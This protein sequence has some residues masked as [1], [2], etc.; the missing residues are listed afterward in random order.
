M[1]G[2]V[3]KWMQ[4]CVILVL[5]V[6]MM[7]NT[8]YASSGP[9]LKKYGNFDLKKNKTVT[10]QTMYAGIGMVDQKV[11][12]SDYKVKDASLKGYRQMSCK[13]T[14]S[15]KWKVSSDEIHAMVN[16]G[17]CKK[18]KS[19]GGRV[20]WAICDYNT[21]KCIKTSSNK[22]SI[23]SSGFQYAGKKTYKD[24][25]GCYV[26]ITDVSTKL[27]VVYPKNEKDLCL[28][29]GGSTNLT[30]DNSK[31]FKGDT[32]FGKTSYYDKNNKKLSHFMKIQ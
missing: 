21:G 31:F 28:G 10:Y 16:S 22:I 26:T 7:P 2:Q 13:L 30:K 9:Y 5:I 29:V 15:R 19:I 17:Y 25:H 12:V 32:A 18:N 1:K 23:E 27:T 6:V 14:F 24:S 8:V 4:L 3:R 11:K 20:F